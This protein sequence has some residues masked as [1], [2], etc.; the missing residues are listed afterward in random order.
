MALVEVA[1]LIESGALLEIQGI[2]AV[3]GR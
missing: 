1:G 3:G 2:A